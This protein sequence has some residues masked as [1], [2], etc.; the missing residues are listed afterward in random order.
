[1]NHCLRCQQLTFIFFT[2]FAPSEYLFQ[3]ASSFV[4]GLCAINRLLSSLEGANRFAVGF[5]RILLILL[6][7][8]DNNNNKFHIKTCRQ[9]VLFKFFSF[10]ALNWLMFAYVCMCCCLCALKP[11][12][13]LSLFNK[14]CVSVWLN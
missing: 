3:R 4:F 14:S 10:F 5:L 13:C 1:M 9:R 11:S 6:L 12:G 7:F 8:V 2:T